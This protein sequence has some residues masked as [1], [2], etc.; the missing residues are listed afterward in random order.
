[1]LL[2]LPPPRYPRHPRR[3]YPECNISDEISTEGERVAFLQA[4]AGA[5]LTKA[6]TKLNI[7]RLYAADG[8]AV[9]ELLKIASL[10]Y[11]ATQKASADDDVRPAPAFVWRP[12]LAPPRRTPPP[13]AAAA[14]RLPVNAHAHTCSD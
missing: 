3:Y 14:C 13:L 7:K 5:M 1:M 4:V 11:K 8:L 6:R 12:L 9:K 2:R 10:L